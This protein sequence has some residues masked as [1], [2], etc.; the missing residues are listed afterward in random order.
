MCDCLVHAC[1]ELRLA[2]LLLLT[3]LAHNQSIDNIHQ[4][5]TAA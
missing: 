4:L 1:Q 5:F 2:L 3:N